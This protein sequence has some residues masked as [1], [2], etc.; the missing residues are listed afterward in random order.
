L[1]RAISTVA[2]TY[3]D[4]KELYDEDVA[5]VVG[6]LKDY[7]ASASG[8]YATIT[9]TLDNMKDVKDRLIFV[10]REECQVM[11]QRCALIRETIQTLH[12]KYQPKSAQQTAG[13]GSAPLPSTASFSSS[14]SSG[15]G[16]PSNIQ[17]YVSEVTASLDSITRLICANIM[18]VKLGWFARNKWLVQ[19]AAK[20]DEIR[21]EFAKESA[22]L[23]SA[24]GRL[25]VGAVVAGLPS[26]DSCSGAMTRSDLL[27]FQQQFAEEIQADA[28]KQSRQD[29]E[30]LEQDQA[31]LMQK[32]DEAAILHEK[33]LQL[34]QEQN[35]RGVQTLATMEEMYVV[36]KRQS[37][38]LGHLAQQ[39]QQ[40]QT[41]LHWMDE[42]IRDAIREA[43]ET[44]ALAAMAALKPSS[45]SSPA[46]PTSSA[47]FLRARMRSTF[48]EI[49]FSSLHVQWNKTRG[50]RLGKG[51]AG[52]VWRCSIS[53]SAGINSPTSPTAADGSLLCAFKM[54]YM[55]DSISDAA[56]AALIRQL[57]YEAL[58][59]WTLNG[60]ANTVQLLGAVFD[61]EAVEAGKV[62]LAFEYANSGTLSSRLWT[63]DVEK[64]AFVSVQSEQTEAEPLSFVE[65]VHAV[66]QLVQAVTFAHNKGVVHRDI[67]SANVLLHYVESRHTAGMMAQRYKDIGTSTNNSCPGSKSFLL[68][69]SDFGSARAVSRIT[70]MSSFLSTLSKRSG[71]MGGTCRWSPPELEA[72]GFHDLSIDEQRAL[73]TSLAVDVYA[74]GCVIGEIMTGLPPYAQVS[75]S[76]PE[77]T[78][79]AAILSDK[80][81]PFPS[82]LQRQSGVAI[83]PSSVVALFR[84]CTARNPRNP[85]RRPTMMDLQYS[86]WHDVQQQLWQM[87]QIERSRS[88]PTSLIS[89][90]SVVEQQSVSAAA[91]V[92]R[93]EGT[94]ESFLALP[95]ADR[96]GIAGLTVRGIIT[97]ARSM[98]LFRDVM[99]R[100]KTMTT[101][102]LR[103]TNIGD[104]GAAS[105][106]D[107]IK[108]SKIMTTVNLG[109]NW[110]GVA[111]A[112]SIADAIKQSTT[113]TT[114]D[115]EYNQ[116]GDAGAASIADAIKQSKTMTMVNLNSDAIGVVGAAS[117]ASFHAILMANRLRT[118]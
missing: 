58:M 29:R 84:A 2:S 27:E 18:Q 112:A 9:S 24:L 1:V 57:R 77:R 48:T 106:S 86:L 90:S 113:M 28:A 74:L 115:L 41:S 6:L 32:L 67:K 103:R 38:M 88:P 64:D 109:S 16:P 53:S 73:E 43:S 94:L 76:R 99:T 85:S 55:P 40:Q 37:S 47:T 61:E 5:P 12:S 92:R 4:A 49:P 117:I 105:I 79:V 20:R 82:I 95:A 78:V 93:Y 44:A 98:A 102:D 62:G 56:L 3:Q 81:I 11:A 21:A 23:D 97:D 104:A 52:E 65:K 19:H 39:Q 13:K 66:Y 14:S 87:N 75:P 51:A 33:L 34:S 80:E 31:K 7:A 8:A 107:A 63:V 96:D 72:G 100:S 101:V 108:Q 69:L 71:Q 118:S 17:G 36:V 89:S 25:G 116:I 68:R 83:I 114:V 42:A 10:N 46:S 30:A 110:I 70:G 50:N 26:V 59:M 54:I 22:K 91:P 111:G 35:A 15:A 45:V 60:H